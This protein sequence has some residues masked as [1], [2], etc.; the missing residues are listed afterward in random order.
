M[1]VL[2]PLLRPASWRLSPGAAHVPWLRRLGL[3]LL[4]ISL[5]ALWAWCAATWLE[6][7]RHREPSWA[8]LLAVPLF[9]LGVRHAW[10]L[11][12]GWLQP[13][14]PLTL[15]WTGPVGTLRGDEP[16]GGWRVDEWGAQPIE[17]RLLWD[18][19]HVMLLRLRPWGAASSHS[20][21][22]W[23]WLQDRPGKGAPFGDGVHRLRTLV[24]L[25]P[26]MSHPASEAAAEPPKGAAVS[27]LSRLVA[28]S[29]HDSPAATV[30]MNRGRTLAPSERMAAADPGARA[31][32]AP[33]RF[34]D[35]FPATQVMERWS[36]DV[37]ESCQAAG[38]RP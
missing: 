4:L 1:S 31:A 33:L 16:I 12:R 27:T 23:I 17:V 10:V 15:R 3:T 6:A 7:W 38:G 30:R 11:G 13:G 24:C 35:D 36:D 9:G 28:S 25:P 26:A 19:Q 2:A 18:W 14:E 34:E 21:Q 37:G 22:A 20:P 5:L 29:R 8:A 32:S